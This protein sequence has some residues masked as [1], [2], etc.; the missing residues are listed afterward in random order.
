[1]NL[2]IIRR[3]LLTPEL[4]HL[5]PIVV[6]GERVSVRLAAEPHEEVVGIGCYGSVSFPGARY[7]GMAHAGG[8]MGF[9]DWTDP[10]N[11]YKPTQ[12]QIERGM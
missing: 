12:W 4:A 10:K 6:D 1:M 2:Y 7:G 3:D 11:D 9:C 5:D 8:C